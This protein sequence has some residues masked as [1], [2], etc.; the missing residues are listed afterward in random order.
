[1]NVIGEVA[2]YTCILVDDIVDSGGTLVNAAEALI[3][4]GAK[5][6]YGLHHPRRAVRRRRRAHRRRRG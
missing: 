3:A 4:H 5:E 1:M 2:G 6:V